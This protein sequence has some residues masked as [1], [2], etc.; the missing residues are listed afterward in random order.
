VG[1]VKVVGVVGFK[2][3]ELDHEIVDFLVVII[4]HFLDFILVVD[5]FLV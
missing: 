2:I 4:G 1:F 3:S 5:I